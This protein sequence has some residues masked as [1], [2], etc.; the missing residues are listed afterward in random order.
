MN[1]AMRFPQKWKTATAVTACTVLSTASYAFAEHRP[2]APPIACDTTKTQKPG[3]NQHECASLA[4]VPLERSDGTKAT[5]PTATD[6]SGT[7]YSHRTHPVA[8][9]VVGSP[10]FQMLRDGSSKLVVQI[11]GQ[12]SVARIDEQRTLTIVLTN[13]KVPV[14]NNRNSLLTYHFNTALS[15][16]RLV[17]FKN[18]VYLRIDL[19]ASVTPN[20]RLIE[21]VAG[22][23]AMLEVLFPKGEY[24]SEIPSEPRRR[25]GVEVHK[26][27]KRRGSSKHGGYGPPVP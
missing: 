9:S 27:S 17:Q 12:P 11:E 13:S 7:S 18:D 25:P 21:I 5:G 15:E 19:R 4:P 23:V 26:P 10:S 3:G 20:V 22:K 6:A 24:S 16:A 2:D 1:H 14:R 8:F